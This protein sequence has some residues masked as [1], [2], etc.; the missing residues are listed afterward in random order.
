MSQHDKRTQLSGGD[1][2]PHRSSAAA[3]ALIFGLQAR[4]IQPLTPY[5]SRSLKGQARP[6]M[7]AGAVVAVRAGACFAGGGVEW[8]RPMRRRIPIKTKP[9]KKSDKANR[10]MARRS[11]PK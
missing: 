10:E 4:H 7:R 3:P 11:L 1:V 5:L 6:T 9:G 2:D 8:V